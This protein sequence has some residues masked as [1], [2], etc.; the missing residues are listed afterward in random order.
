M[1]LVSALLRNDPETEKLA[2]DASPVSPASPWPCTHCGN[3]AEIEVVE[4][5]KCD[6]VL[7]TYW[8]CQPCQTWAVTPATIREP[9]VWVSK[10]EQ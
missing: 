4:P 7:L 2:Q 6:G 5:R 9:P 8:H 1:S 3:P 10:R